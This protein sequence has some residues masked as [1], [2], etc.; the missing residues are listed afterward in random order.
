MDTSDLANLIKSRRSIRAWQDK[1]VLEDTILKAIEIATYAP[2]GGNRQN[3]RFYVIL[4]RNVIKSIA[5]AVQDIAEQ[6]ASWPEVGAWT[7]EATRMVQRA[8][9]FR[10]APVLIAVTTGQYRSAMDE[11][12]D[13]RGDS[14]PKAG[15]IHR[16]RAT[17]DTKIQSIASVVSYL[18]LVLHQIGLGAV[19]MTGPIQAKTEIEKI[20]KVPDG[21][22]FVAL[23]P[24]GYPAETPPL[25]ERKPIKEVC[26]V[27]R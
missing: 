23:I 27:I 5:D 16:S 14:D 26:E 15:E 25:K 19:W 2:N 21:M 12:I 13:A 8:S 10:K 24:A 11:I 7:E 1:P 9:F 3:W 18:C 4:N 20:L 17:A 6:V 22:D